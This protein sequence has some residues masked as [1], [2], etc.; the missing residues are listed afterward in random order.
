MTYPNLMEVDT[1][2]H[3]NGGPLNM[4]LT[5]SLSGHLILTIPNRSPIYCNAASEANGWIACTF[6]GAYGYVMSKFIV[7]TNAYGST[8]PTPGSAGNYDGRL[9]LHCKATVRGGR[10]ALRNADTD[11][12]ILYIP[13]GKKIAVNTNAVQVS[14]RL[15]AVYA[16]TMGT[17]RHAYI[18]VHYTPAYYGVWACQKYGAPLLRKGDSNANVR[19]F[20]E[21]LRNAGAHHL[22]LSNSFD[23]EMYQAVRAFQSN[24]NLQVD[25]IVGIDTKE[26]LFCS[27]QFG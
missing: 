8:T 3:G 20:K 4:R 14:D 24:H 7:G 23:E 9:N 19:K 5:P 11:S 13:D 27:A 16:N 6:Q 17:V 21:D 25:G 1:F 2:E 10:L 26:R 22:Q 18:E 15:R 12:L